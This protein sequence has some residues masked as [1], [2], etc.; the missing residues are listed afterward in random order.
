MAKPTTRQLQVIALLRAQCTYWAESNDI[1][2]PSHGTEIDSELVLLQMDGMISEQEHG[3]LGAAIKQVWDAIAGLDE[4]PHRAEQY[5]KLGVAAALRPR[6]EPAAGPSAVSPSKTREDAAAVPNA[7]TQRPVI[8]YFSKGG[9]KWALVDVDGTQLTGYDIT[10]L[11]KVH[12][13]HISQ[14]Q[15]DELVML[16]P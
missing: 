7:V 13:L 11:G 16:Q 12:T 14:S 8:G 9:H 1:H 5:A 15:V 3:V 6:S 4:C 10:P 2:S